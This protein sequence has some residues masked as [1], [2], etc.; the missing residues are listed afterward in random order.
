M[1]RS[2]DM[3][4]LT[5]VSAMRTCLRAVALLALLVAAATANGRPFGPTENPRPSF[6]ICAAEVGGGLACGVLGLVIGGGIGGFVFFNPASEM[7]AFA[8]AVMVG[9]PT[10]LVGCAGG[11]YAVGSAFGQDG[12]FLPTLAYTA[13]AFVVAAGFTIGGIQVV[14]SDINNGTAFNVGMGM[15]YLGAA[16]FVAAPVVATYGY[17]RSRPRDSYGSRFVPGSVDLALVRDAEGIAHP[18]LNV[19]LLSVRF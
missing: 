6:G 10:A 9:F 1:K 11:T 5:P 14:N 16:V 2:N 8:G 17:N 19:R 7:S 18:S 15:T 13:G 4:D 3:P 12:R